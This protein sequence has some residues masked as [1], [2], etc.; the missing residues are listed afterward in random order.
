MAVF[1]GDTDFMFYNELSLLGPGGDDY[2]IDNI[3]H[4]MSDVNQRQ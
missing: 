4:G 1:E 3:D 2:D